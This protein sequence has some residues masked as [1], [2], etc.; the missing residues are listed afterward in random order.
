VKGPAVAGPFSTLNGFKGELP[1]SRPAQGDHRKKPSSGCAFTLRA[2]VRCTQQL[3]SPTRT[4]SAI[5]TLRGERGEKQV[6]TLE[7]VGGHG[8]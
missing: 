6:A 7:V 2:S 1:N 3:R 4:R 5:R 8:T